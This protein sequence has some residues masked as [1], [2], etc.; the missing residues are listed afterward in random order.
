MECS[1]LFIDLSTVEWGA[2]HFAVQGRIRNSA[3][4]KPAHE[5][6]IITYVC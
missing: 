3:N 4:Y 2:G 5:T 6:I 1:K